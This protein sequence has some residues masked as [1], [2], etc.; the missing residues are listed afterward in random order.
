MIDHSCMKRIGV[1][2]AACLLIGLSVW[3]RR[4]RVPK[5][6]IDDI[7]R[8]TE[9][10]VPSGGRLVHSKITE[11]S[12]WVAPVAQFLVAVENA[13]DVGDIEFSG[14]KREQWKVGH[15]EALYTPIL[16]PE[17]SH[18]IDHDRIVYSRTISPRSREIR[19]ITW[20]DDDIV[21]LWYILDDAW[22]RQ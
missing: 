4:E 8:V 13:S 20:K 15:M 21:Y 14:W 18:S 6:I 17:T 11:G 5:S 22:P 12:P 1:L 9:T 7:S 10:K 2:S 19:I 16:F 3:I